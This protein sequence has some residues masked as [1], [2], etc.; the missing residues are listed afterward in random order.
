M[1]CPICNKQAKLL[2]TL[3]TKYKITHRKYECQNCYTEFKTEEKIKFESI[4]KYLRDR[5]LD[6]GKFK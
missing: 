5:Y 2:D 3:T 6:E 1:I 4:P